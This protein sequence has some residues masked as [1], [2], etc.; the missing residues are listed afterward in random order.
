M[1]LVFLGQ[2]SGA[3]KLGPPTDLA[4]DVGA[5]GGRGAALSVHLYLDDSEEVLKE[6]PGALLRAAP[7]PGPSL[8]DRVAR[9]LTG[10]HETERGHLFLT[11]WRL[12]FARSDLAPR[13]PPIFA[14]LHDVTAV[15]VERVG[16]GRVLTVELRNGRRYRFAC[17]APGAW[18]SA[19]AAGAGHD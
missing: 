2:D 1:L 7:P 6:G 13:C 11:Q 3:P 5:L 18:A 10:G 17:G 15:S 16:L 14:P 12:V 4:D 8:R 19:I 9:P